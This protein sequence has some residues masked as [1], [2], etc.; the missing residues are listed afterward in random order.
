MSFTERK[1]MPSMRGFF[2]SSVDDYKVSDFVFIRNGVNGHWLP[3]LWFLG[4]AI[5]Q[6]LVIYTSSE[7][8]REPTAWLLS[9]DQVLLPFWK[10][11]IYLCNVQNVFVYFIEVFKTLSIPLSITFFLPFHALHHWVIIHIIQTFFEIYRSLQS[12]GLKILENAYCI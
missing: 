7:G 4:M 6:W 12:S 3:M 2:S 1:G 10:N 11:R 9:D 5:K 8:E